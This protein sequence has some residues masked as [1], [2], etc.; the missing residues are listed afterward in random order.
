MKRHKLV[1]TIT[2]FLRPND[3]VIFCGKA[4]IKEAAFLDKN[5]FYYTEGT[6]G[7]GVAIGVAMCTDKRVFVFCRDAD[8]ISDLSNMMQAAAAR[9]K[10]LF[11]IILN[12]GIYQEIDNHPTITDSI[13]SIKGTLFNFG[14]L[15]HDFS[16]FFK[17]RVNKKLLSATIE[18]LTGPMI[19][20]INVTKGRIN[21]EKELPDNLDKRLSALI[22][23]EEKGSSLFRGGM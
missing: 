1:E 7:L 3:I 4:I 11:Y 17:G 20:L 9:P 19:I 6:Y 23:N 13:Y 2:S 15:V 12:E 21:I 8:L 10:N 16:H 5:N 18:R 22:L 14:F